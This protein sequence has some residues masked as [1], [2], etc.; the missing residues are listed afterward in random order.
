MSCCRATGDDDRT[1]I[2]ALIQ[3]CISTWAGINPWGMFCLSVRVWVCKCPPTTK[4]QRNMTVCPVVQ[5]TVKPSLL[6]CPCLQSTHTDAPPRGPSLMRNSSVEISSIPFGT[7][8]YPEVY[9][10]SAFPYLGKEPRC[11]LIHGF[12]NPRLSSSP[13]TLRTPKTSHS[14]ILYICH[15]ICS[16]LRLQE[17][18]VKW[19]ITHSQGSLGM[20]ASQSRVECPY[21]RRAVKQCCESALAPQKLKQYTSAA[22]D[23]SPVCFPVISTSPVGFYWQE[24]DSGMTQHSESLPSSPLFSFLSVMSRTDVPTGTEQLLSPLKLESN[25]QVFSAVEWPQGCNGLVIITIIKLVV[26]FL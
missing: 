14:I 20:W 22:E 1:R 2:T 17:Q 16:N 6:P 3:W 25:R 12:L 5:A 11:S 19:L 10:P 15:V 9:G 4:G 7:D 23:K 24:P 26:E 8:M 13:E 21:D 18:R